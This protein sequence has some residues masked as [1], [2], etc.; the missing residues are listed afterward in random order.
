M[1]IVIAMR[2]MNVA[3]IRCIDPDGYI[4]REVKKMTERKIRHVSPKSTSYG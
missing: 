4:E 2:A 1:G 3:N